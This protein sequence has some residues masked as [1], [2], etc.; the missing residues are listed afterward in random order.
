MDIHPF[1]FLRKIL[2]TT[3]NISS[4]L[5]RTKPLK[6]RRDAVLAPDTASPFARLA[7]RRTRRTKS[8]FQIRAETGAT[9]GHPVSHGHGP[10]VSPR[11]LGPRGRPYTAPGLVAFRAGAAGSAPCQ[12]RAEE[13]QLLRPRVPVGF[14]LRLG[15]AA[16]QKVV[17]DHGVAGTIDRRREV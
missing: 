10:Q 5:A 13:R 3:L 12:V 7:P 8:W 1:C 6:R 17:P 16:E 9:G 14:G 15:L 11:R 2:R 4:S